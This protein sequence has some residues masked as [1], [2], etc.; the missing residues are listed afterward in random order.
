MAANPFGRAKSGFPA[1]R[2]Q[3]GIVK[4]EKGEHLKLRYGLL[5]HTGD[6]KVGKVAD[7]FST[8]AALPTNM[9]KR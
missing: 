4:L 7:H 1:T 5:L 9:S 2:G 6:A 3:T 8:F